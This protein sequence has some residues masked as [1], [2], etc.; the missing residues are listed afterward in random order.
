ML[1]CLTALTLAAQNKKNFDITGQTKGPGDKLSMSNP[2]FEMTL[3]NG[4]YFTIGTTQG[5]SSQAIDDYN[6]ITYGHPYALT[7]FPMIFAD[8]AWVKPS[9]LFN[10]F[11]QT[12]S[13]TTDTLCA[14]FTDS[15]RYESRFLM[16]LENTRKLVP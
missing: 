14:Y 6:Q 10:N 15:L 12:L 8:T 3:V 1:L 11:T 13:K 16:I 7:S 2:V 9:A 4:A 5:R